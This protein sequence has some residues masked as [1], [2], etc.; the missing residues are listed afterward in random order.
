MLHLFGTLLAGSQNF[1]SALSPSPYS[2]RIL[3]LTPRRNPTSCK[4][5]QIPDAKPLKCRRKD[6][7]S[8]P[9]PETLNPA[10]QE[11]F[12]DIEFSMPAPLSDENLQRI[13]M[14]FLTC[15][16]LNHNQT[17]GH[18]ASAGATRSMGLMT[19]SPER[20]LILYRPRT[21]W[22]VFVGNVLQGLPRLTAHLS[23]F[24]RLPSARLRRNPKP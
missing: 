9:K 20:S 13:N 24:L 6:L 12:G 23:A 8:S 7:A 5:F 22:G 19:S 11:I 4:A 21:S 17:P 1:F 18:L 3:K 16:G 15:F 10:E 14:T 2:G